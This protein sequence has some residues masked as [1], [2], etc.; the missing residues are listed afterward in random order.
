VGDEEVGGG[1]PEDG[2]E[3]D[4][5]VRGERAAAARPKEFRFYVRFYPPFTYEEKGEESPSPSSV[6][7]RILLR[8]LLGER[9]AAVQPARIQDR[10]LRGKPQHLPH[11]RDH[12]LERGEGNLCKPSTSLPSL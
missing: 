11:P 3:E 6:R 5:G 9:H 2:E 10:A 4:G 12:Q 8:P 7:A 1:G